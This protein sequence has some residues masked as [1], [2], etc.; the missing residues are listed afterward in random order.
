MDAAEATLARRGRETVLAR[1]RVRILPDGRLS[2]GEA[3]KYLGISTRTLEH[4]TYRGRGP[5]SVLIANRRYY[6]L[7]DLDRFILAGR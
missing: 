1:V 5:R 7:A 2:R 6:H 4:W 3:A